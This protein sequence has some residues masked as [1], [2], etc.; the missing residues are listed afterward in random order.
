[1]SPRFSERVGAVKVEIQV[2]TMNDALRNSIWNFV[3]G[4]LPS[5]T[6]NTRM[7]YAA[8]DQI[9]ADV[10]RVPTQRV[11]GSSPVWWLLGQVEKMPWTEAYELLEYVVGK[12]TAWGTA[13]PGSAIYQANLLLAREHSGYRFVSG[14]LAPITNPTE[15]NEIE[16]AVAQAARA[17]LG[18]VRD[19]IEQALKLFGRR[20]EPDYRNAIKEAIS[21]V[22]GVVKSING[23]RGGGLHDALQAVSAQIEMHPALKAGLER[24]YGY[25]SDEGGI[26]HAMLEEANVD[27]ADARFMIVTCSAFVNFLIVKAEAAGLLTPLA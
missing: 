15:I 20:P 14:E 24:L 10:L 19:H 26:R 25:T 1:V 5:K 2:G 6:T 4:L 16:S 13:I 27:E 21:A 23:S 17:R 8:I 22:E 9:V 3:H 11:D 18:G 7:H 12:A